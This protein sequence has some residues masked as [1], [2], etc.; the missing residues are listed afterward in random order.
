MVALL[1]AVIS[2][3]TVRV[4][5]E[6]DRAQ[7]EAVKAEEVSRLLVELFETADPSNALGEVVTARSLLHPFL[8]R[9]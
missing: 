5:L 3:Y 7:L 1:A 2:F 9:S 6:R 8:P 4:T